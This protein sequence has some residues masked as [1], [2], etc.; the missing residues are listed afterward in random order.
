MFSTRDLT[1]LF[2]IFFQPIRCLHRK[3]CPAG[4]FD[5][6]EFAFVSYDTRIKQAGVDIMQ[7]ALETSPRM[8]RIQIIEQATHKGSKVFLDAI[9]NQII[10]EPNVDFIS[11]FAHAILTLLDVNLEAAEESNST[12]AFQG[13]ES[14]DDGSGRPDPSVEHF[15]TSFTRGTSALWSNLCWSSREVFELDQRN[16]NL[17]E[18]GV[19]VTFQKS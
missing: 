3:L 2:S 14:A 13:S 1:I 8:I 12:S 10:A 5:L 6:L 19:D 4:L 17:V 7:M 18:K 15:W 9:L 16:V 11:Q